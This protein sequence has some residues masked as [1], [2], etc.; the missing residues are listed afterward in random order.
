MLLTIDIGN[1]NI[2][3][4]LF[5]ENQLILQYRLLPPGKTA[6]ELKKF[7][8]EI[9]STLQKH[10]KK[11]T[12]I[13]MASVSPTIY[14]VM[15]QTLSSLQV[16]LYQITHQSPL[17]LNLQVEHPEKVGID[18][19]IDASEAYRQNQQAVIVIDMGT[20]TTID[21]VND[22]GDFLGGVI[23]PGLRISSEAL[24]AHAAQLHPVKFEAPQNVI[25]KNTTEC[26]QSGMFYGYAEMIDGLVRRFQN[27]LASPAK[28]IAT[29]GLSSVYLETCQS[30]QEFDNTLTLNGMKNIFRAT[31]NL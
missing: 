16:P 28:V 30:I 9:Q 8:Q 12:H 21:A 1:T 26:L 7:S 13:I 3:L 25:G 10:L 27:E 17:G 29:G 15:E 4:G 5:Q 24:Y 31:Q 14:Q 11:I 18:R 6:P 2:V 19:L 20:A 23:C 22:S